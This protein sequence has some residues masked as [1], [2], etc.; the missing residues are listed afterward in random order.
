MVLGLS[1][2]SDTSQALASG[3]IV[4][5][6]PGL[7]RSSAIYQRPIG[8][9]PFGAALDRLMMHPSPL[10]QRQKRRVFA[11]SQKHL[12]TLHPARRLGTRP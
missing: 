5:S 3:V 7:G 10:S 11:T 12:R 1:H 9:R 6:L 2:A 4:G 8:Q